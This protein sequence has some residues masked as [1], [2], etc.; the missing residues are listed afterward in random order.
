MSG[1]AAIIRFDG[2]QVRPGAIEAMTAA[3]AY[4]GPDGI[5]RRTLG[6][7]AL[8]HCQLHTTAESLEETQPLANEDDSLILVM[9][10]WLSN[11]QELRIDLLARGAVLRSR[12]DAEL[13]LRA[14]EL[15][16]DQCP[17]HIDGEF[18]FVIWDGRCGE[19]YLARD[20]AGL[21]PLH[22]HWDGQRL[23]VGSDIAVVL[24]GPD[25][26]QEPNM[27]MLAE[28][29]AAD[30]I[31][32]DETVWNGVLRGVPARWMRF[33]RGG[34]TSGEYWSPPL[35]VSLT[36]QTDE[37]YFAHYRAMFADCVRRC[38]RTH[39]PLAAA[40]SG[41]L[42]SSA[43]FAVAHDLER[44][45]DL[46]AP[47]INGY[48]YQTSVDAPA[49]DPSDELAYARDVAAHVGAAVREVPLFLPE[50]AWFK[51]RIAADR[52]AAP[53]PNTAMAVNLGK[54][55]VEDGCRVLLNGEGGDEWLTGKRFYYAE[56]LAVGD[57]R[58]FYQSLREDSAAYGPVRALQWV[59]RYGLVYRLPQKLR[60]WIGKRRARVAP[61]DACWLSRELREL[62]DRRRAAA[63]DDKFN[64]IANL[65]RR[66]MYM[67]LQQTFSRVLR[68]HLSRQSAQHGFDLRYP[69]FS[70]Q[71]IEF[72]FAS[73]ERMRLRGAVT[74]YIHRKSL[75]DLLPDSVA[76]RSSKGEFSLAFARHLGNTTMLTNELL[77][78]AVLSNSQ[79]RVLSPQGVG[80]LYQ[81]YLDAPAGEKPIWE[82]WG[83]FLCGNVFLPPELAS[84][85]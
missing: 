4:R 23:I 48:T 84:G 7:M 27:G 12:S 16:G 67:E 72:A 62:L 78:K 57:W 41:G 38:S 51:Q 14:Y 40:V 9:D 28:T 30:W 52:D 70:R 55:L 34:V 36:Y 74:K 15:W 59:L 25:V 37:E 8:G 29:I 63:K 54:A 56:Q 35:E 39:L 76:S 21:R 73:P 81:R 68:D 66:A 1:I 69:M 24:A 6:S 61:D 33:G 17:A 19:V 53:Y 58:A 3:M 71:F 80:R 64:R 11:W 20:H 32:V 75:A 82:L 44:R 13:V 43:I 31:S 45:G 65:P 2:G 42:D 22:Y 83:A 85:F 46:P 10:G 26:P 60:S 79:S 50:L 5:S 18:A 49:G 77:T 47:A